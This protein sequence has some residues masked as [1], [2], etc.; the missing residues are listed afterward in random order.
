[1]WM[2]WTRPMAMKLVMMALPPYDMK[3]RGMPVIGMMPMVMPTFSKP[4]PFDVPR[5][6]MD[7]SYD[8]Q[9][10][11]AFTSLPGLAPRT[12]IDLR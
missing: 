1:M 3:G 11:S 4:D 9:R 5:F 6:L 8:A 10:F 2:F 7:V 12:S